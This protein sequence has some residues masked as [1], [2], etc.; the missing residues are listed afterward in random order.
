M[1]EVSDHIRKLLV[2]LAEANEK[3]TAEPT[4]ACL[5]VDPLGTPHCMNLTQAQSL[6]LNAQWDPATRCKQCG[7]IFRNECQ[8]Q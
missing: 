4:G 5:F 2:L 8:S 7:P 6:V 3:N 1:F